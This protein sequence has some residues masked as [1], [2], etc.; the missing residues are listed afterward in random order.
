[1][2]HSTQPTSQARRGELEGI[3]RDDHG[4]TYVAVHPRYSSASGYRHRIFSFQI[5]VSVLSLCALVFAIVGQVVPFGQDGNVHDLHLM[6]SIW[7]IHIS[8]PTGELVNATDNKSA[9]GAKVF[10]VL[11]AVFS[12]LAFVL[13]AVHAS[14]WHHDERLRSE[15]EDANATLQSKYG[16][17]RAGSRMSNDSFPYENQRVLNTC[18]DLVPFEVAEHTR[19]RRDRNLG[20]TTFSLLLATA[21]CALISLILISSL[22]S[23]L[24]VGVDTIRYRAGMPL[25]IVALILAVIAFTV[26]AIPQLTALYLC[27]APQTPHA[28]L[29]VLGNAQR[30]SEELQQQQY[31]QSAVGGSVAG[32]AT[33]SDVTS[34][35]RPRPGAVYTAFPPPAAQMLTGPNPF[36]APNMFDNNNVAVAQGIRIALP[37]PPIEMVQQLQQHQHP[38]QLDYPSGD[39]YTTPP[40]LFNVSNATGGN[41][42]GV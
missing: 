30:D 28:D 23:K 12:L 13:A 8:S 34:C 27:N 39:Y 25:F 3:V 14:F 38:D 24:I 41:G 5:V 16:T 22:F 15:E 1:M 29:M 40:Q 35:T 42:K 37:G 4:R 2:S 19:R 33:R 9:G 7:Y 18:G 10:A 31:S 21:L 11:T 20:I 32:N 17:L 6:F 26:L 36:C